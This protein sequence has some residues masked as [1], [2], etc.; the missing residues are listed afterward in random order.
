[1]TLGG[2]PLFFERHRVWDRD[3]SMGDWLRLTGLE[4]DLASGPVPLVKM[5]GFHLTLG[6]ARILDEPLDD[7]TEWWLALAWRP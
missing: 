7:R 1:M 5:P 2:L 4:W 6:V 3:G